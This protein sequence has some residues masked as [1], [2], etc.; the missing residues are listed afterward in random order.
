VLTGDFHYSDIKVMRPGRQGYADTF[1]SQDNTA[2]VFQV[3]ASGL[4][5]STGEQNTT[6]G[7]V[8]R[9]ARGL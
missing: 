5:E 9:C 7:A 2:L 8:G 1:G 4:T 6:G 3:M